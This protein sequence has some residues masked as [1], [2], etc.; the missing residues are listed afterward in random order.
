MNVSVIRGICVLTIA[1]TAAAQSWPVG[2]Q[3][4]SWIQMSQQGNWAKY[5]SYSSMDPNANTELPYTASGAGHTPFTFN[6]YPAT[7]VADETSNGGCPIRDKPQEVSATAPTGVYYY[8]P[9]G[10]N[11][12]YIGA[13]DPPKYPNAGPSQITT[14]LGLNNIRGFLMNGYTTGSSFDSAANSYLLAATYWTGRNNPCAAG[15]L[16]IG[17]F[18]DLTKQDPVTGINAYT[19]YFS[20]HTN[21]DGYGACRSNSSGVDNSSPIWQET[22]D[23]TKFSN[24]LTYEGTNAN[25]FFEIY[26]VPSTMGSTSGYDVRFA[27]IDGNHTDRFATCNVNGGTAREDCARQVPLQWTPSEASDMLTGTSHLVNAVVASIS[28]RT[29]V[30]PN[31]TAASFTVNSLYFGQ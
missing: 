8:D 16:E 15:N 3:V 21:C 10:I 7:P 31:S 13:N 9:F 11:F 4:P 17:V 25:L 20:R 12:P 23:L 1:G 18:T 14:S 5:Q 28:S 29:T 24:P 27:I 26:V 22:S 6:F 19:F 2:D 30:P